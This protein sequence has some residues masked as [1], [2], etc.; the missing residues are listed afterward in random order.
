MI[1]HTA[2]Q[3]FAGLSYMDHVPSTTDQDALWGAVDTGTL[4]VKTPKTKAAFAACIPEVSNPH[5]E[6]MLLDFFQPAFL[7]A[8]M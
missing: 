8:V 7:R 2:E 1:P 4:C 3:Q 5:S 6:T